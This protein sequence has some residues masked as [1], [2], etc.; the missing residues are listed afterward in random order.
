[1]TGGLWPHLSSAHTA[2]RPPKI[3]ESEC[4]EVKDAVVYV[5]TVGAVFK[6]FIWSW[7]FWCSLNQELLLLLLILQQDRENNFLFWKKKKN[8]G[9]KKWFNLAENF[10]DRLVCGCSTQ[11]VNLNPAMKASGFTHVPGPNW[12]GQLT[13][14]KLGFICNL[15]APLPLSHALAFF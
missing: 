15:F 1:M 13:S 8:H 11:R 2:A 14:K 6:H 3:T 9:K 4:R 12:S 10:Q 7:I 5:S